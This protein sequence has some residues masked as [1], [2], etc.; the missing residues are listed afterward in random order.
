MLVLLLPDESIA[1]VPWPSSKCH[2]ATVL[3]STE[4]RFSGT[5]LDL[6]LTM[7]EIR[8]SSRSEL[9]ITVPLILELFISIIQPERI[10]PSTGDN[11]HWGDDK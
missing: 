11:A 3:T 2:R 1:S 9:A 8:I 5:K 4:K 6:Y 7:F 10:C